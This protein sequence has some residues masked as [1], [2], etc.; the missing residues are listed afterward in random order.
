MSEIVIYTTP[1]CPYCLRAKGL[2]EDKGIP[3]EEIDV[4]GKPDLR[5]E[6]LRRSGGWTVPQIFIDD[7]PIG[8]CDELFAL[9][10]EG[11]LDERLGV[12]RA[13]ASGG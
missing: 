11:R 3:F 10:R 13:A 7:D 4:S 9:E 12:P 8:G 1:W 6:M 5:E 2:L